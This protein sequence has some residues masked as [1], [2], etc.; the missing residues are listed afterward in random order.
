M[1]QRQLIPPVPDSVR[2]VDIEEKF[3]DIVNSRSALLSAADS[4]YRGLSK[5][6]HFEDY[7]C[8]TVS[9]VKAGTRLV[10]MSMVVKRRNPFQSVFNVK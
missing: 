8:S 4:I 2:N 7:L 10:L 5:M 1:E 6:Q 3:Q 9:S